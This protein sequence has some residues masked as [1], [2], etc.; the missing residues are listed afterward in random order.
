[1]TSS[2][3]ARVVV[4]GGGTGGHIE[5]AMA[6]AEA[7][8]RIEPTVTVTAL[9][10]ARGLETTVIPARGVQLD[11]MPAV[12]LPRRPSM[13]LL[14]V[15]MRLRA[16]V[17]AARDALK[18]R[19]AD[20]LVGFGGY[21]SLPAYRAAKKL[22]IPYVVHEANGHAG[23]ANR[24]GA[25]GTEWVFTATALTK[26]P[27]ARTIGMPLRR[28]ISQLDRTGA[29]AGA[30]AEFGLQPDRPTLLVTGG[31]QGAG[32]INQAMLG[33]AEALRAA[34]IQVLHVTGPRH[35]QV[36]SVPGPAPYVTRQYVD[37]MAQAYAAADFV[38]C[39]SGAMTVA[40]LTAV[41]LPAAYVPYPHSNGEQRLN[42]EPVVAAGGGVL[43]EDES[44]SAAWIIDT[45]LP[46]LNDPV[47]LA[48]MAGAAQHAGVR[49]A[50][51]VLAREVL[52][53]AADHQQRTR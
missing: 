10:T 13:D 45:V 53:A 40:E 39:R 48:A 7:L 47:R 8:R 2:T 37:D 49:D 25:R 4:A 35:A 44:V 9:G 32:S 29:Q 27:H 18:R 30:R 36:D 34:G 3:G 17:Q 24:I 14:R 15:P 41:G 38:L 6:L 1:M 28:S 5:P 20:V 26:L 12:P 11:L 19:E 21:V 46:V 22:R 31:S 52:R 16:A 23:L 43:V 50:D 42:A 33:S 51:E